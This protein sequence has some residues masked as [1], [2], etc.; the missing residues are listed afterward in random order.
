MQPRKEVAVPYGGMGE[1]WRI[2]LGRVAAAVVGVCCHSY[3]VVVVRCRGYL[4]EGFLAI[5][6]AVKRNRNLILMTES[7]ILN[8]EP[9]SEPNVLAVEG[10]CPL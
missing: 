4:R 1:R 5:V 9:A 8:E 6:L 2:Y 3:F 7:S 10:V